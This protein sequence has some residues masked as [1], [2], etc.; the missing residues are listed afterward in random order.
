ML[1]EARDLLKKVMALSPNHEGARL[2][3]RLVEIS[4]ASKLATAT[5]QSQPEA[6]LV[7]ASKLLTMEDVYRIRLLELSS[8]DRL[9]IEF[10]DKVLEQFIEAMR[11]RDVLS[12]AEERRFRG[13]DRVR[14]AMYMLDN[15][16]RAD[17]A[18]R[19]NIL[20]KGD[21]E[22]FRTF[23]GR[24]WPVINESCARPSCHGGVKG[25]GQL[26]LF[27]MP[28]TD[29]RVLYTNFYILHA[30]QRD[31]RKLI[32][33][34]QPGNSMLLQAGLPTHIAKQGLAHPKEVV[35]PVFPSE[36]DRNFRVIEEWILTLRR[37]FLPPGYRVSYKLPGLQQEEPPA[38]TAPAPLE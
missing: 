29:D 18:I 27:D 38:T 26:K 5:A 2:L 14:Q 3:L 13:W 33:R 31:G 23:R 24:I 20:V 10:R 9:S 35:P 4:L 25:A 32:N 15:T 8:R 19:D 17:T 7:D 30:W 11:G 12:R 22:V 34:D 21:P 16:D 1:T 6:P 28:V 36:R 37:P